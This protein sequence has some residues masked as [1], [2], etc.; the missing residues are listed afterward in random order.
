MVPRPTPITVI[1]WLLIVLSIL[2]AMGYLSLALQQ[3]DPQV[4][5][6]LK[7]G[8]LPVPVQ[9]GMMVAGIAIQ[10]AC[11]YAILGGKNWARILYV[12]WTALG[13]CVG[14]FTVPDKLMLVPGIVIFAV[15][16]YFL[17][18]RDANAFFTADASNLSPVAPPTGSRVASV[19][20]YVLAGGFFTFTGVAALVVGPSVIIKPLMLCFFST[21]F[22]VCLVCG[23]WLSPESW[24]WDTGVTILLGAIFAAFV[25]LTMIQTFSTPELVKNIPPEQLEEFKTI[26]SDRLFAT[27]W[28]SAWALIGA[29]LMYLG[30]KASSG[31]SSNEDLPPAASP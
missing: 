10:F 18:R 4:Q 14:L 1:G 21:P 30:W 3:N 7:A 31:P 28:M 27:I 25:S 5:A 22:M 9:Y 29:V 20:F 8:P 24:K 11:G 17:Y 6:I 13:M 19:I 2:S 26:F 23:G 15:I 12:A 16:T